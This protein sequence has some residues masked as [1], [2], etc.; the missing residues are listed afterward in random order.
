MDVKELGALINLLDDPDQEIFEHI[1]SK[2]LSLG[3]PAIPALES[4]WENSMNLVLQARIENVLHK[5]QF[6]YVEKNLVLWLDNGAQSLL[7]GLVIVAK[8]QYPDLDTATVHEQINRIKQDVWLELRDDLTSLEKVKILN[9]IFFDIHGFSGNTGNFHSP[10]NSFV[11]AVLEARKGNPLMLSC[12]Y[13]I[14]AQ[15]LNIPIMGINLPEL[16]ILG[17]VDEMATGTSSSYEYGS[18]IIFYI[19]AFAKGTVF[20]HKEIDKFLAQIK[21]QPNASHYEPCQNIDIIKRL[22]RNLIFAFEKNSDTKR[23]NEI[24]YILARITD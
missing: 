17:F 20:G 24:K 10:N 15:S 9:R 23:V 4:A 18:N 7:D 13:S 14:V 12:I 19:N 16:F 11:N 22:L 2:L 3:A 8:Y 6:E 5:I 21:L 1:E